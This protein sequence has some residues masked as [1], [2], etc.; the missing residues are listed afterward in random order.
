MN[1]RL[2]DAQTVLDAAFETAAGEP[3]A[4]TLPP[5]AAPPTFHAPPA[6]LSNAVI[7]RRQKWVDWR[8][9]PGEAPLEEKIAVDRFWPVGSFYPFSLEHYL[10]SSSIGWASGSQYQL[11]WVLE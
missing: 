2:Q 11:S 10:P 7:I 5:T 4:V 9:H 6:G 8:M 1:Q 3:A